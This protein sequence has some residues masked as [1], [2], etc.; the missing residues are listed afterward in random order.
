L[1]RTEL[2]SAIEISSQPNDD[3]DSKTHTVEF[4]AL[5]KDIERNL[6]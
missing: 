2:Q 4:Q 6:H 3:P 5:M 1:A